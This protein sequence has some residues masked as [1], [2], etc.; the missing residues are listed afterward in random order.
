ML[1]TLIAVIL[2]TY[3]G[4]LNSSGYN[5]VIDKYKKEMSST[6]TNEQL[7]VLTKICLINLMVKIIARK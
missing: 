4:S 1:F 5:A 3:Q 2:C 6:K 7:K